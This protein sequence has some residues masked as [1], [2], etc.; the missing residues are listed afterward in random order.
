[1]MMQ[2]IVPPASG[3]KD[4]SPADMT[5]DMQGNTLPIVL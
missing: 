1:M 5:I 2:D 4:K 3:T